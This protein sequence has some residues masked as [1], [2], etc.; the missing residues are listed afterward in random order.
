[1]VEII[2]ENEAICNGKSIKKIDLSKVSAGIYFIEIK[3][4][5]RVYIRKILIGK[6]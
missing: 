2:Y 3:V 5:E 6:L 4:G 1:M